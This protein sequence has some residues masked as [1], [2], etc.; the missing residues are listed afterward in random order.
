VYDALVTSPFAEAYFLPR[1][2][3]RGLCL[4]DIKIGGS[5]GNAG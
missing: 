1:A 5:G 3:A 4:L 2:R